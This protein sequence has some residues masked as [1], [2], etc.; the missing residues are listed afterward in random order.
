MKLSLGKKIFAGA[1]VAAIAIEY[2]R[3]AEQKLKKIN[4]TLQQTVEEKNLELEK[5][6]KALQEEIWERKEA[7][8]KLIETND[9]LRRLSA[10]L[11]SIREEERK[12]IA[13]EIHDELGQQLTVLK[14]DLSRVNKSSP[15]LSEK[16]QPMLTGIDETIKTVKRISS[17][18][19]P[20]VLDDLGLV[21]ALEWHCTEFEKRTGIQCNFHSTQ[22]DFV[23]SNDASTAV[24]RILQ[25]T[26][27][28]VLRHSA[29]TE[30]NIL[31]RSTEEHL[32]LDINDNG[33]GIPEKELKNQKSLGLLGMQER[34]AAFGGSLEITGEKEKGTEVKLTM[35]YSKISL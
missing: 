3:K 32:I 1:G 19:R 18:L 23:L 26:L 22:T 24:F 4:K 13:R 33:K 21:A 11:H 12:R 15:Q 31:L 17:E 10:H 5:Y 9:R 25:E 34:A 28:N 7:E 20:G 14:M 8:E 16:I 30:V 2:F 6:N 27:T 35:P 29:A